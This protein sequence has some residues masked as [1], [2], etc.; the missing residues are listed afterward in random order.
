MTVIENYSPKVQYKGPVAIGDSLSISFPYNDTEDIKCLLNQT[1]LVFNKD[2]TVTGQ[3]LTF[4]IAATEKDTIT[5]YRDTPLDQQAEFPQNN[6]FN[7]AKL[8]ASLDKICMQQQEQNEKITR[9]VKVP[10]NTNVS[11]EGSLPTPLPNR[12][13]RINKEAT[14]FEFVPYDLD[15]RLDTFEDTV[16]D[17]IA[18][19]QEAIENSFNEFRN[20][21]NTTIGTIDTKV[22]GILSIATDA[23]LTSEEAL[24]IINEANNKSEQAVTATIEAINT[25][26]SALDTANSADMKADEALLVSI[27]AKEMS[28]NAEANAA[29]AKE[30][31]ELFEGDIQVVIEAAEQIAQLEGAVGTAVQASEA[32]TKAAEDA[33]QAADNAIAALDSKLDIDGT[34]IKAIAD[35]EGNN[36]TDTYRKIEDS[37]DKDEID[38]ALSKISSMPIGTIYQA[39]RTDI[40]EGSLRLDGTE[41]TT[42]FEGFVTN[43]LATGKII[44]KS[45][46]EWQTEYTM[47]NGNVGFFGYDSTTGKFK[48]PCIQAG[49]FLAQAV[50]NGEFGSFLNSELKSH[51]HTQNA[52]THSFSGTAASAG[53]H[54]H[55]RG[56][57][58]ITGTFAT[59]YNLI[60]QYS[61][62]FFK[63]SK[64][65]SNEGGAGNHTCV[66]NEF[67]ASRSWTGATSSNGAH[68][69][70]V[71]GTTGST[72]ATNQATGGS[73]TYPKHIR[74]PF[75][76]VVSN[77]TAE[78]PSQVAWDNFVGNLN[79]KLDKSL[80]NINEIGQS[81]F[82]AKVNKA[83]D[84]M[85]G[86]LTMN[87]SFNLSKANNNMD[88]TSTTAPSSDLTGGWMY[89]R[90]KN[91]QVTGQIFNLHT[92]NNVFQTKMQARRSIG[93]TNK[94]AEIVANVDVDGNCYATAPASA[95]INSIV[96]TAGIY[97]STSG[98]VKLG[99]G[100]II[101]WG[102]C[103]VPANNKSVTVTLPTSFTSNTSYSAVAIHTGTG[104]ASL[105][106]VTISG[107]TASSF[108]L[109]QQETYTSS[110]GRRWIAIGF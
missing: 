47:T 4:K 45:L 22:D 51:T 92:I 90:D 11:F 67:D 1:E 59:D 43:Y 23:K 102:N 63:S 42:G 79:N 46:D 21:T 37:Y 2:Y 104:G 101:Q 95:I 97:R 107:Q 60:N 64:T 9:S 71:S 73:D 56:T 99:N 29:I 103:G 100:I 106:N 75:F 110:L 48:T 88:Y 80:S 24:S 109:N 86:S 17:N 36:I 20:E 38:N 49:T 85:T 15:E 10:I 7:S 33:T 91:W 14:G 40:P 98:Y 68:T 13:L 57:M 5:I 82:D 34:A 50:L 44:S 70:T 108:V 83:G 53:A 84:T 58:N 81:K 89:F 69:H 55:T 30:K 26:N 41:F 6:R 35:D 105:T 65:S 94:T 96:T 27:D 77:V 66:V 25:A 3:G 12:I 28:T 39:I 19:G 74:Y 61:G 87:A 76:V 72:T 16:I 54:T 78:E 18:T 8:N 31:V 32:A 52:H 62:A 93:G